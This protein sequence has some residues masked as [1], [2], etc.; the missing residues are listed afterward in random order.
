MKLATEKSILWVGRTI[1]GTVLIG[2]VSFLGNFFFMLWPEL[3]AEV[4]KMKGNDE[5]IKESLSEIK[6][7]VKELRKSQFELFKHITRRGR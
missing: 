3:R 6:T 1:V 2:I 7:D 5:I 4:G